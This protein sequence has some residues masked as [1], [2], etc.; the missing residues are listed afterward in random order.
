ME[1]VFLLVSSLATFALPEFF[2]ASISQH[3][4]QQLLQP[5]N[6]GHSSGKLIQTLTSQ[7][8]PERMLT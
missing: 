4:A 3:A 1:L 2:P 7:Y 5:Q 8:S 6:G